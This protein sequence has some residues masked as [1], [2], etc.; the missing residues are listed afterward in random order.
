MASDPLCMFCSLDGEQHKVAEE[1]RAVNHEFSLDGQFMPLPVERKKE[2]KADRV[3][4]TADPVL[5][6]ALIDAGLLKYE[7][8]A[9][10]EVKLSG[11]RVPMVPQASG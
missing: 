4:A 6:L 2:P 11:Q 9:A 5:R 1:T 7:D 8:L 3:V 10:A